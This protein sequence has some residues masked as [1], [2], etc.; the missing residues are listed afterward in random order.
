[1]FWQDNALIFVFLL[2][3]FYPNKLCLLVRLL[4]LQTPHIVLSF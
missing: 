4:V 3:E 2:F 1:M